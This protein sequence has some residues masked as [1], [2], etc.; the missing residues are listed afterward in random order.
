M[1]EL[2]AA[3]VRAPVAAVSCTAAGCSA[4]APGP[5][6]RATPAAGPG[7]A[8]PI[9]VMVV[10][11]HPAIRLGVRAMLAGQPDLRVVAEA[12]THE[13]ALRTLA[14]LAPEERPDVVL[15]DLHLGVGVF[16]GVD[17]IRGL[18]ALEPPPAVLVLSAYATEQDVFAAI[19]AG[20]S[21][22]LGKE[23]AAD[24]LLPGIRAAARG[25][26]VLAPA[27]VSG[28]L[29]RMRGGAP[30]LSRREEEV[31]HLLADGLSNRQISA[32]LFISEATA[33]SHLTNIYAKL[34]VESRGAAVAAARREG[35]LRVR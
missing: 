20:A 14:E 25:E 35:L 27:V 28:L 22:Y 12:G 10:D 24:G 23:T 2:G 33:K 11:D 19:D 31:L 8:A 4:P 32:R 3:S 13:A 1:P 26:S 17:L 7:P 29:R 21:G 15:L 30:V 6:P 5:A 34:G 18:V 9:A 16:Q